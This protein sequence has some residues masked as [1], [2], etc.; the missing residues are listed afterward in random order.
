MSSGPLLRY[1]GI[2]IILM[3]SYGAIHEH[4]PHQPFR[5]SLI[6]WEDQQ[7]VQQVITAGAPSFRTTPC[8]LTTWSTT[9]CPNNQTGL[10]FC[11]SSNPGKGYC[12]YPNE[13]YCAYWGC[14]T[15]ATDWE[16]GAGRDKYL[17]VGYGPKGCQRLGSAIQLSYRSLPNYAG[18]CKVLYL[19]VTK[20]EDISW[21]IG[22]M[23]G[24]RF[25]SEGTDKGGLILI[26]KEELKTP[27]SV[28]PNGA[29][30]EGVREVPKVTQ[31][32]KNP[33]AISPNNSTEAIPT[34]ALPT[35]AKE[36]MTIPENGIWKVISASY[37]VLNQ[38][39][40]N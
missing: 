40:P 27:Q 16:L 39:N 18:T 2:S 33:G 24:V 7:T 3:V 22:K 11:P 37:Q 31:P 19:N 23:W 8:N 17:Q 29:L 14:E 35:T 26:K 1:V 9:W 13:Y 30:S 21:L 25:Y 20:P 32:T 38:T 5:W 6:R 4:H 12:N 28:G 34:E 36:E 10:Y 15:I